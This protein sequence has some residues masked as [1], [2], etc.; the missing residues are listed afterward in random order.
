MSDAYTTTVKDA[1]NLTVLGTVAGGDVPLPGTAAQHNAYG[2]SDVRIVDGSAMA[3]KLTFDAEIT[4]ASIAKYLNL[5][6]TA[7]D[8]TADNVR[9]EYSGGSNN[10]SITVLIDDS[11]AGSTGTLG[12]RE[13]F[14]FTVNGGAGNDAITVN[15]DNTGTLAWY[16]NQSMFNNVRVNGGAGNDTI[17]TPDTGDKVIDAGAGNDTVYSDNSGD[18]GAVWVVSDVNPVPVLADLEGD[19]ANN[20]AQFLYDGKLTVTFSGDSSLGNTS[21]GI[22]GLAGAAAG[23]NGWEVTV[24]IPTG[25]NYTV[26]QFYLNQA[27]KDAINNDAVLSKLL[28]ATDGPGN[29]LT[30][31]ALIDGE[32]DPTDLVM[33][34]SEGTP[35]IAGLTGAELAD[36]LGA[37]KAFNEDSAETIA[38]ADAA[39]FA[40]VGVLNAVQG[41]DVA[42]VLV[43]TG[44]ESAALT[45]NT[46]DLGAGV[47]VLVLSSSAVANETVVFSAVSG[48]DA[49]IVNFDDSTN[50]LGS[51]DRLDFTDYLTNVESSSGS[52]V[53]QT[54][55]DT[56]F[57]NGGADVEANQVVVLNAA[58]G[59]A[60]DDTVAAT[61]FVGMTS[62]KFLT[63]IN[64]GAGYAG[65]GDGDLD[66]AL[67]AAFVATPES[68]DMVGNTAM[69]TVLVEN[70]QNQG[71]YAMFN[72]T[73]DASATGDTDFDTATLVGYV[74]FGASIDMSIAGLL[75]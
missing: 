34:V 4:E 73:W 2:F 13:D 7:N 57:N 5:T 52:T 24:D 42:Q 48:V 19:V 11:A 45:D 47:D 75:V 69:A 36:V 50:V 15:I 59:Q 72:V 63:A 62:A 29:T 22:T 14:I 10:D 33:T 21:G 71:E 46:I 74:D 51:A 61:T 27:I 23:T 40:S 18:I 53:S 37:W 25:P 9:F 1:G 35:N 65:L 68:A 6:D 31:A 8:P 56:I 20:A 64:G 32:F 67:K 70:N 39:N 54:R 49:T 66:A 58:S 41:M 55:I 3:G 17:N 44:A 43:T 28:K 30:V 16:T 38:N 26:N 60:F 12:A